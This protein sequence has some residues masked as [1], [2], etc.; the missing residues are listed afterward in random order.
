MNYIKTL[1][2]SRYDQELYDNILR[3]KCLNKKYLSDLYQLNMLISAEF[4]LLLHV[5]E[6]LFKY[7]LHQRLCEHYKCL[8][9]L[10]LIEWNKNKALELREASHKLSKHALPE[11][12]ID[13]LTFGFWVH[14]FDFEYNETIFEPAIADLFPN[15]CGSAKLTRSHLK[16]IFTE[17]LY[18]RNSIAHFSL[19]I[20]EERRILKSYR[21]FI[22]LIYWMDKDY[23][24]M[25]KPYLK[26]KIYY[27]ILFTCSFS[28]KGFFLFLL[29][30]LKRLF[31]KCIWSVLNYFNIERN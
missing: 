5:I 25:I 11:Q 16:K 12:I 8:N 9:W 23:Y 30:R 26:F 1:Y 4:Y 2:I 31:F 3:K 21:Q 6:N 19:I 27:R 15:F 10:N 13:K 20:H 17:A 14:L 24:K 22:L 18:Y 7:K 29:R 28:K